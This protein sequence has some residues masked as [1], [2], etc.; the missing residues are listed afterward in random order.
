LETGRI[1]LAVAVYT[2][3]WVKTPRPTT[4]INANANANVDAVA[5]SASEA[6]VGSHI[7]DRGPSVFAVSIATLVIA[8]AFVA[9]RLICRYFIVRCIRW[10]DKVMILAWLIAFFLSFTIA[11]GTANGLGRH[12]ADINSD[13]RGVLRRCEYAFSILYVSPTPCN[14]CSTACEW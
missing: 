7:P 10:D 5:M 4:S 2:N 9:A 13:Q 8:T 3:R 1:D 11:L 12:D 6:I 14:S